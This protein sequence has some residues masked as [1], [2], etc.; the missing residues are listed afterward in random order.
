MDVNSTVSTVLVVGS[1]GS[2]GRLVVAESVR[3][4]HRTRALMRDA[5]RASALDPGADAV[6][7]DMTD[8]GSLRELVSGVD[9]VVFTQGSHGG[10]RQ[11]EDVDYG[12]VRNVLSVLRQPLRIALMTAIGVTKHTPGHD[13]KRR[14]ERL[15][16]ASGLPYTIVRPG[17]FD[18]NDADQHR[19]EFLQGDRRWA[20]DPSDGVVSREQIAQVLVA[21]LTSAAAD[22]KTFELVAERGPAQTDLDPLF[23]AL[24]PDPEGT[25]DAVLDRDNMP[26]DAEP[27]AVLA[28]LDAARRRTY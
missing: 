4:G 17:W 10:A 20:S 14:G 13:W 12:A 15:V 25:S 2:I 11:A 16:R 23:A 7:G 8:A 22:H 5:G 21:S 27:A 28:D 18:Y 19:L 1:T 26:L 9:A 6:V 24:E 3:R